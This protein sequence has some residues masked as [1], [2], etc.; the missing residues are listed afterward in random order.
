VTSACRTVTRQGER[1][2]DRP[3]LI[4]ALERLEEG[5]TLVVWKLDRLGRSLVD[6]ITIV[7]DL[8]GRGCQLPVPDRRVRHQHQW[9]QVDVP[10]HGGARRVRTQHE[11]RAHPCRTGRSQGGRAPRWPKFK[12]R[13]RDLEWLVTAGG[14]CRSTTSPRNSASAGRPRTAPTTVPRRSNRQTVT[15]RTATWACRS[16]CR[17]GCRRAPRSCRPGSSTRGPS[18]AATQPS[19]ESRQRRG[20]KN[21]ADPRAIAVPLAVSVPIVACRLLLRE[22]GLR[23]QPCVTAGGHNALSSANRVL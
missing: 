4:K 1:Q 5:D 11:P 19:A 7:H 3:E 18:R 23:C 8:E 20:R 17:G 21:L 16:S 15:E 10:D 14:P 6:L 2:D 22:A 12:L 13:D 9:R